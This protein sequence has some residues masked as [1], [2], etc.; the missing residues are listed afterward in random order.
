MEKFAIS[1]PDLKRT[2]NHWRR[3]WH[4]LSKLDYTTVNWL[5][6]ISSTDVDQTHPC[7]Q[8]TYKSSWCVPKSSIRAICFRRWT[9]SFPQ[10]HPALIS[11]DLTGLHNSRSSTVPPSTTS[12]TAPHLQEPRSKDCHLTSRRH[13][14]W[15]FLTTR[16]CRTLGTKLQHIVRLPRPCCLPWQSDQCQSQSGYNTPTNSKRTRWWLHWRI[17]RHCNS[18]TAMAQRHCFRKTGSRSCR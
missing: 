6:Q 15:C 17:T 9:T 14:L 16:T 1:K 11:I 8:T 12:L 5:F 13:S 3:R 10:W 18:W 2:S 4:Q 7:N